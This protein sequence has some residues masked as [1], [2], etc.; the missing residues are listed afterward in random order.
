LVLAIAARSTP[1]QTMAT[2]V[3]PLD[4]PSPSSQRSTCQFE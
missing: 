1:P 4:G 2:P 3:S